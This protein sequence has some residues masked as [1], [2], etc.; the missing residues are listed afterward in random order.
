[1]IKG[2]LYCV[3]GPDGNGGIDDVIVYGLEYTCS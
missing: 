2:L 3:G 1:M